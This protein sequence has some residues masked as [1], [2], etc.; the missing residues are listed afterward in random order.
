MTYVYGWFEDGVPYYI[1]KGVGQRAYSTNHRAP[2]P[3][4]KEDVIILCEGLTDERACEIETELIAFFGRE[5]DGGILQNKRGKGSNGLA[6]K[7]QTEE[8]RRKRS[9]A[10][11]GKKRRPKTPEER[12]AISDAKKGVPRSEETKK[13]IGI[14][15]AERWRRQK[16]AGVKG[17]GLV[18]LT[19]WDQ[20]YYNSL[21]SHFQ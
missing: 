6:G 1:G 8:H 7:K 20:G 12:K 17:R 13:K 9:L 21:R 2:R 18:K 3:A 16:E 14:S 11:K 10:Q 15:T 4:N 19:V 5:A